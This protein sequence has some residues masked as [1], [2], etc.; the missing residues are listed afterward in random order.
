VLLCRRLPLYGR[1]HAHYGSVEAGGKQLRLA[2]A[3]ARIYNQNSDTPRRMQ[4]ALV[5]G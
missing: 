2:A 3:L 1:R 4:S 5:S